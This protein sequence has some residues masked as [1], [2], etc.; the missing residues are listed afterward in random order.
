MLHSALIY[1]AIM[2]ITPFTMFLAFCTMFNF[3]D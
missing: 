1:T 2:F 3:F